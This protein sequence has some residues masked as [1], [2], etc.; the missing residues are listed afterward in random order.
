[1]HV[2]LSRGAF[3]AY[4]GATA[5]TVMLSAEYPEFF[6]TQDAVSGLL[7]GH[8]L[9]LWVLVKRG[10]MGMLE[11]RDVLLAGNCDI[12]STGI[13][14]NVAQIFHRMGGRDSQYFV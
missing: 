13:Y 4:Q 7:V 9:G 14:N 5:A 8:P 2:H 12:T 11:G 6:V 10:S 1:V 3:T